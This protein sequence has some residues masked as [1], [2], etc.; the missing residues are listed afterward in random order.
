MKFRPSISNRFSDVLLRSI[1]ADR[2]G[3]RKRSCAKNHIEGN[4]M[5]TLKTQ[6]KLGIALGLL[7]LAAGLAAHLALTD[8]YH[9][10]GDVSLEWN[11]LRICA[12]IITAFIVY[13]LAALGRIL[14]TI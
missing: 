10:E 3:L 7:S 12:V 8:I 9:A 6:I 2:E 14:K 11:V 13:A 1:I 5:N 4:K